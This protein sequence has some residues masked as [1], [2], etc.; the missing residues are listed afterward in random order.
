M[1]LQATVNVAR[2]VIPRGWAPLLAAVARVVPSLQQYRARLTNGGEI[3]LDLREFMCFTYFFYGGVP[4]EL[5]TE[6]LLRRVLGEGGVFVDVGANVGYFTKVAS[7]LVGTSGKVLAFEPMP[8][9]L[10]LLRMNTAGLANVTVFP[11]ALSDTSGTATFYVRKKGD[12]S[13]LS[14]DSEASPVS[15]TV[16]TLDER[17]VD[18]PRID[19]IKIDVEGSELD[20]LRGGQTILR[21]YR[22]IIYFE[23]LPCFAEPRGI[24][25][26]TFEEFFKP[27]DYNLRWIDHS[28]SGPSLIGDAPSTYVIAIPKG[29]ERELE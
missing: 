1:S 20:V 9:A 14:P 27:L 8:A 3:Y 24:R 16:S 11:L 6:K 29:R 10:R 17:L 13:S 26:E 2:R 7:E 4:H 22:P 25:I 5:G 18:Q 28:A 12:T 21:R 15:V 19:L 23:F